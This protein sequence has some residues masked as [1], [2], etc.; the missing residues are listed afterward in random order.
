MPDWFRVQQ[1]W[2]LSCKHHLRNSYIKLL[3]SYRTWWAL[4]PSKH[5][6]VQKESRNRN[7]NHGTIPA[8]EINCCKVLRWHLR[9]GTSPI[10]EAVTATEPGGKHT[11]IF[12][13]SKKT[14]VTG[15]TQFFLKNK[16]IFF[17]LV[18]RKA[19]CFDESRL[20]TAIHSRAKHDSLQARHLAPHEKKLW[21]LIGDLW[22]GDCLWGRDCSL[23][24]ATQIFQMIQLTPMK[25]CRE[26]KHRVLM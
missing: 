19:T 11:H 6:P 26:R 15:S 9:T 17:I 12:S 7:K 25:K 14:K 5:S 21:L 23:V 1:G 18:M 3:P 22:L 13:D 4:W 2:K 24:A 20:D 8:R 16:Q 10:R